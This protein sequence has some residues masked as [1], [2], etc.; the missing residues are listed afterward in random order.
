M[1]EAFRG[2]SAVIHV[3]CPLGGSP[4][5]VLEVRSRHLHKYPLVLMPR[6]GSGLGYQEHPS[7][8]SQG[9]RQKD[10]RDFI[11]RVYGKVRGLLGTPRHR[12]QRY[13]L[14]LSNDSAF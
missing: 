13:A 4:E 2:V 9:R 5:V 12:S 10:C 3:G 11:N 6:L 7:A 14:E 1:T 8:C